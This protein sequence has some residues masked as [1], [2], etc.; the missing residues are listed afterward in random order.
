MGAWLS[1]VE[2]ETL[3]EAEGAGEEKQPFPSGTDEIEPALPPAKVE[4]EPPCWARPPIVV[5]CDAS[6]AATSASICDDDEEGE[7]AEEAA[8]SPFFPAADVSLG[9]HLPG[10]MAII[11]DWDDTLM[12]TTFIGDAVQICPPKY[13]TSAL[14][15]RNRP[16]S[17]KNAKGCKISK[18]FPCYAALERHS[19]LVKEALRQARSVAHVAIV[20]LA[21]RPWVF[22]SAE[23]YL[24]GLDFPG[25]LQELEIPVYYAP[26]HH[27]PLFQGQGDDNSAGAVDVGVACKCNA[28]TEFLH[29]VCGDGHARANVL[30][31]GD[32][33]TEREA[34]KEA[35][36]AREVAGCPERPLCKTVKLKSD[37]SLKQVSDELHHLVTDGL[38][39]R[40]AN[41]DKG[42]D[43][44]VEAIDD[45]IVGSEA[46]LGVLSSDE[47]GNH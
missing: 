31:I 21:S 19:G 9:S 4:E 40:L 35:L 47:R 26:E 24:P 16:R 32:S 27:R 36:R 15:S 8:P 18:D 12:P 2:G 44:T 3:E 43:I 7:A 28:M 42:F 17:P 29:Q 39:L 20:T 11:F 33:N 22:E 30:S 46:V 41:F 1:D 45:L 25:L 5:E 6:T 13:G 34:A 37:P 38:L 10:Q 23:R 14:H